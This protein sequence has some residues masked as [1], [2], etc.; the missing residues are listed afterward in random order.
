M[1]YFTEIRR[2]LNVIQQL[3]LHVRNG[4]CKQKISW[5]DVGN[6]DGPRKILLKKWCRLGASLHRSAAGSYAM[7]M[8]PTVI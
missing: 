5:R 4:L 3:A 1:E 7:T 6:L 2:I 8:T